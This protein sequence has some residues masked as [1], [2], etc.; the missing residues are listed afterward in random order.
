MEVPFNACGPVQKYLIISPQAGMGNRF[1]ALVSAAQLALLSGREL[2]HA[3]FPETVP[4]RLSQI[5]HVREIQQT[6]FEDFFQGSQAT[7][8]PQPSSKMILR[9]ANSGMHID[10]CF[11]EWVPGNYWFDF[12]SSAFRTLAHSTCPIEQIN[13][14]PAALLACED[15]VILLETSLEFLLPDSD[16]LREWPLSRIYLEMCVPWPMY[17]QRCLAAVADVGISIRGG[18]FADYF[19]GQSIDEVIKWLKA[20]RLGALRVAGAERGGAERGG[21][22]RGG[23]DKPKV[24]IFSDDFAIRDRV[25]H[26]LGS[27]LDIDRAGLKKQWELGFVEFL[28]LAQ[29]P[30]IFG[31][32]K[33]SFAEQASVFCNHHYCPLL[34]TPDLLDLIETD[35]DEER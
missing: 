11:S 10:R 2:R 29:C 33:S 35:T 19:G 17:T 3:W 31:T 21:D 25:R 32:P 13:I 9:P 23:D 7:E 18:E 15:P 24:L 4:D 34:S 22:A 27:T 1:R 26:E 30:L 12:Q 20:T 6:R 28:A 14:D 16:L 8:P 5:P